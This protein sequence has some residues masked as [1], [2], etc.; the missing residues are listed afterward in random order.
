[1]KKYL[2]QK[3]SM[4]Y[5]FNIITGQYPQFER[6]HDPVPTGTLRKGRPREF[7]ILKFVHSNEQWLPLSFA[8]TTF[9]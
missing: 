5:T 9:Y 8:T 6:I 7:N 2:T 3:N 1:M 4:L